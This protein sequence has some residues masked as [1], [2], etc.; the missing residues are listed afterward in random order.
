MASRIETLG[1]FGGAVGDGLFCRVSRA[2]PAKVEKKK[3]VQY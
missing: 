1:Y 3:N 2:I